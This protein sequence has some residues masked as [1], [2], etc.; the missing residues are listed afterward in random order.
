MSVRDTGAEQLIKDTA[1]RMFFAEGKMN[2]TTHDIAE[3]AGVTRTLVNYYFRSKDILFKQVLDEAM[4]DMKR[5]FDEVLIN[6]MPFN[7]K[8]ESFIEMFYEE[9]MSYPYKESFVISEINSNEFDFNKKEKSPALHLFIKEIQQEMDKGTVKKMKP[10][11]FMLNLFSLL[12]YPLITRPLFKH[13]FE[14]DSAQYD[15]LLKDRK[16]MI[17]ELLLS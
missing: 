17:F 7:K 8:L 1:K 14:L 15:R 4:V 2:A 16:K 9:A 11:N 6:P 13:L 5:R 3:A 10:F 12:A